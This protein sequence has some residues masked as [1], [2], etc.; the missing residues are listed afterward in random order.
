LGELSSPVP[1]IAINVAVSALVIAFCAWLSERRPDL[2]GFIVSLPLSTLLVLALGQLQH[3][4]AQRGAELAKSILLA[5]PATAVFFLPFLLADRLRLSF[6]A[7]YGGGLVLLVG[8]FF[9]HR[10][11]YQVL[12]K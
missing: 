10:F 5:F 11:V 4:D 3:G 6:W 2:A 1:L 7:A 9:V 8:A 12:L